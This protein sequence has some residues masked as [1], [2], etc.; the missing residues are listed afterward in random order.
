MRT[1]PCITGLG[2]GAYVRPS[3][4]KD[5][6]KSAWF[7]AANQIF[8]EHEAQAAGR[9][10]E[11]QVAQVLDEYV[12]EICRKAL[13]WQ[14]LR[15]PRNRGRGRYEI[16]FLILSPYGAIV[17]EVKNFGGKLDIEH[18]SGRWVQT[19]S[20]LK[21]KI[22]D[23]PVS[24]SQ[25]KIEALVSFLKGAGLECDESNFLLRIVMTN[26]R[27]SLSPQLNK[28][29]EICSLLQLTDHLDRLR[30]S[31]PGF[32]GIGRSKPT[33]PDFERILAKLDSLPT[34]DEI[35]LHG[36]KILRGDIHRDLRSSCPWRDKSQS[37]RI[38]VPRH[39][40]WGLFYP[41]LYL[42]RARSGLI[43]GLRLSKVQN[44]QEVLRIQLAGDEQP[45]EVKVYHIRRI[46]YG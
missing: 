15:I 3:K 23:C 38:L 27:L 25:K 36:G 26:T 12:P 24:L 28:M 42:Y 17:L 18:G 11:S 41:S 14:G 30:P 44:D 22:H 1:H 7:Q 9:L 46:R 21:T 33:F 20:M 43:F 2:F 40:F 13:V 29:P 16:D 34:W 8:T 35:E 32:L 10:A 31:K 5:M 45:S 4:R 39:P 37:V 6:K 19:T